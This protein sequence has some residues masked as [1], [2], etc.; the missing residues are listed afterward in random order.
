MNVEHLTVYFDIDRHEADG[1]GFCVDTDHADEGN[2]RNPGDWGSRFATAE[3]AGQFA[4]QQLN[5]LARQT[6]R[7]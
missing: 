3:E 5:E 6:T 1:K 7:V 2:A 4:V